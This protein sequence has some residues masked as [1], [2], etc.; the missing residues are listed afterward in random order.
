MVFIK[1][2]WK[3]ILFA[4][5]VGASIWAIYEIGAQSVRNEWDLDKARQSL[6]LTELQDKLTAAQTN[7]LIKYVEKVTEI[8]VKG[9]ETIRYVPQIITKEVDANCTLTVGFTRL[10]D[11][12]VD[13]SAVKSRPDVD[14]A[15][16]G[17]ALSTATETIVSNYT[18]CNAQ[19]A[20]LNALIDVVEAWEKVE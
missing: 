17:I 11:G 20:Q 15:P 19:R 7:V 14:A 10:H 2:F 6:K 18:Q 4:I 1:M 8:Q 5:I 3:E 12:A 13:A 9:K 16:S